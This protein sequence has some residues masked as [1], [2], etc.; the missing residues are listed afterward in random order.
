[1]SR[2]TAATGA[3]DRP[4][5]DAASSHR[6]PSAGT[7]AAAASPGWP[8][9]AYFALLTLIFCVVAASAAAYVWRQSD[10][11]A[12]AAARSDAAF[13]ARTA[14]GQLGST[15]TDIRLAVTGLGPALRG[16]PIP[17]TLSTACTLT[18]GTGR[19]IE[20]GH[21]DVLRPDGVVVC[22]S[23]ARPGMTSLPGYARASWLARAR[24][25]PLLRAPIVDPA[26][27]RRAALV[28][29]P[30]DGRAIAA[31]FLDLD[32][33]G[34]ALVSLFGGGRPV[35]FLVTSADGRTVIARS[36]DPAR[37]VGHRLAPGALAS[38]DERRDLDGTDRLY[39][40]AT[41][42]GTGWRFYAGVDLAAA[43]SAGD[44]L[45]NRQ[46]AI[47]VGGLIVVLIASLVIYRRVA[48]PISRLR[49]AVTA[50]DPYAAPQPILA[51]GPAEVIGL[52][53]DINGLVS[54]VNHELQERVRAEEHAQ[55]SAHAYRMLFESSPLPMC[56][57]DVDTL[58]VLEANDAAV[59]RYGYAREELQTIG[60]LQLA[61]PA[62]RA[63]LRAALAR[64]E[65]VERVGPFRCNS[66]DGVALEVRVTSY[67]VAFG[68]QEA[69]LVLLEDVGER[70][71]LERQLRQSQR[72]ESLGQLAG[73]VAHD[74]NNLLGVI[75]GFASLARERLGSAD[76]E[77]ADVERSIGHI[78]DAAERA[79]SLTHQLLAF[80]RREVVQPAVLDMGEV[81][82][83]LQP[84]L[85]RTLGDHVELR[86]A[87]AEGAWHVEM[88]RG[89]LEQVL[90][91]LA[92]NAR[93]AMPRGGRLLIDVENLTLDDEYASAWPGLASGRYV[94]VR[95][96]DS[97]EGMDQTTVQ[98]AFEPFFTTKPTGQGTGLGLATVYGIVSQARG[99]VQIYSEL[100]HGTTVAVMLPSTEEAPSAASA[101]QEQDRSI[102]GADTVLIVEDEAPLR[103]V[104]ARMLARH[105]YHVL[106][107]RDGAQALELAS[108]HQGP[109]DLLVAD[110]VMPRM[111]GREVAERVKELRPGV[112]VLFVSGYA[113]P[114]LDAQ[115]TLPEG[116]R[117]LEK[118]FSEPVL[119][120]AVR[121]ILDEPA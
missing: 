52:A 6:R 18:F 102:D 104:T 34:G 115:G 75:V 69:R 48:L 78:E 7:R 17:K 32:S 76:G 43:R 33:I 112:R 28:T 2:P 68:E 53:A 88:D 93:D 120:R 107:A 66:R 30:V 113:A 117:L 40:E 119:L 96:S 49:R 74:F 85:E 83:S 103:E 82:T 60:L 111:L 51:A 73:G 23:R 110:V 45:R 16:T 12:R 94:R 98:R 62:E 71:R 42:P 97:G 47:V 67:V 37:W 38:G 64:D 27:G 95:V 101:A 118:P 108:G 25:A 46:L 44:R 5:A 63:T 22:S 35:E 61:A 14:A 55:A 56:I 106:A 1:M 13:A 50:T 10:R 70:E 58:R 87:I 59:Q 54:S 77:H 89:Q 26:T 36:I 105:G 81:V 21:I 92:V 24:R 86:T 65:P 57:C 31:A 80:A 8:L 19:G 121:D 114:M 15:L 116:V 84:L 79:A 90:V 9:R 39:Q 41:V 100:G 99:R 11:D 91:N 3:L 4:D 72:L 29:A 20:Q 109:I